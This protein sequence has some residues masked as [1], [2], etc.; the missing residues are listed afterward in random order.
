MV[1]K[2][3]TCA[4]TPN[5]AKVHLTA[6]SPKVISISIFSLLE[7]DLGYSAFLEI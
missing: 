5:I 7:K 1:T 6:V 4:R 3:W 2:L